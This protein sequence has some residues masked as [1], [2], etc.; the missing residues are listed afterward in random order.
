MYKCNICPHNC[1]VNRSLL[2]KGYCKCFENA[3]IS[4]ICKHIGEE[5][6]ISGEKGVCNVFFA[7]CNLQCIY[8]QNY[9]IS[10]NNNFNFQLISAEE[11]STKIINLLKTTENI[12]AFVSPSHFL[13]IVIDTID[14]IKTKG[15][16]PKFVYNTNS[17]DNVES[18]KLLEGKIDIYL[19]DFKYSD[20][21]IAFQYSGVKN[22][23]SIALAAIKEMY[24]QKG[25]RLIIDDRTKIAESG[26]I[27]RH[28]LLPGNLYQSKE[29]LKIIAEEIST[30]IH[31]SLMSQYFPPQ[32]IKGIKILNRKILKEEYEELLNYYYELG[33]HNGW[34]QEYSSSDNY[35]P[36]IFENEIF[37]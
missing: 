35:Q 25:S 1:N 5:P 10:R 30:S 20:D 2:N 26:I 36:K 3:Y 29:V 13:P 16:F 21:N 11:L 17:Y 32:K 8:C 22:Y 37:F 7:H 31:I 14:I 24:R 28:L 6:C 34:L 18:I 27:I 12:V 15:Y 4:S 19:P 23:S 33:F 9:K